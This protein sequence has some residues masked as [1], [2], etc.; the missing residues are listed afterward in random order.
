MSSDPS[1]MSPAKLAII[2]IVGGIALV[3]AIMGFSV[4]ELFQEG[5]TE[6]AIVKIKQAGNCV[7]EAS[8]GIPR[9]ISNC[10]YQQG[11]TI[12]ITYKS[13]QPGIQNHKSIQQN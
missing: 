11:D 7:V 6:E 12:S 10:P 3:F 13:P 8:D 1:R 4:K 5:V 2:F 9:E